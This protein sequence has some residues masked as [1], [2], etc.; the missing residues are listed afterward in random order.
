[1]GMYHGD[2]AAYSSIRRNTEKMNPENLAFVCA[3]LG[4][5]LCYHITHKMVFS[6]II[7]LF[8]FIGMLQERQ[9]AV[10][11]ARQEE[12]QKQM[13]GHIFFSIFIY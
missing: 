6:C 9:V 5:G 13:Y 10:V 11:Q 12:Q 1:M 7:Y 8:L 3:V 2:A 4:L